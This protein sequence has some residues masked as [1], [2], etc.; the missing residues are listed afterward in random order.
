MSFSNKH[1][2]LIIR[3]LIL[4][5]SLLL[6]CY[7]I[8]ISFDNSHQELFSIIY[9]QCYTSFQITI[10]W[11]YR[12]ISYHNQ[13]INS[14]NKYLLDTCD[15]INYLFTINIFYRLISFIYFII[16]LWSICKCIIEI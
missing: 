15:E 9:R 5:V 1:N 6:C 11:S 13:L 7:C 3:L 10:Q 8:Y 14:F 12:S 4:L 16:L 2:H